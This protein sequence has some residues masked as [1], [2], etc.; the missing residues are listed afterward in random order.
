MT[1]YNAVLPFRPPRHSC[2]QKTCII[3]NFGSKI[4]KFTCY[5]AYRLINYNLSSIS[6]KKMTKCTA[7]MPLEASQHN[8]SGT[9]KV[10]IIHNNILTRWQILVEKLWLELL[11]CCIATWGLPDTP[12]DTPLQAYIWFL[13][14]AA[15]SDSVFRAL[16]RNWLTYLPTYYRGTQK[17]R[18]IHTL[19]LVWKYANLH[20][21]RHIIYGFTS[22]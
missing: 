6:F 14:A 12:I 10:R 1:N 18:I 16:D 17:V 9:Q 13:T 8:Y 5:D 15:P 2:T 11:Y 4:C 3:H 19:I 22:L 21:M 7:A 20:I